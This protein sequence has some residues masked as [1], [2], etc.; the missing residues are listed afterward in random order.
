MRIATLLGVAATLGGVY[1]LL[2]APTSRRALQGA[3]AEKQADE[4]I[5]KL[6]ASLTQEPC[7]RSTIVELGEGLMRV[8]EPREALERSR[9]FFGRCGAYPRLLWV[10]Y[11]ANERLGK[12]PDA[13]DDATKLIESDPGS[14]DYWCW[15]GLIEEHHGVPEEAARD[16]R[17]AIAIEPAL[18]GIPI[19]LAD[20]YERLGR[21]CDAIEPLEQLVH[22]HPSSS[23]QLHARIERLSALPAC[24]A[25]SGTG[26]AL[27]R[28]PPGSTVVVTRAKVNDVPGKLAVDTGAT[29]VS[30]GP[31][32]AKQAKI[33]SRDW[34]EVTLQTAAGPRRA[35]I[36][37]VNSIG[38]AGVRAENIE[39]ALL[40]DELPQLDGLLGLSFLSRFALQLDVAK[41]ELRLRPR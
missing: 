2:R 22:Y 41:G 33:D 16:Y 28:F 3:V 7:D 25:L 31:R 18:S 8:G 21:P 24:K 38:V 9:T 14:K 12:W 29:Y 35:K 17:Q 23:M 37:R 36:G 32:L 6:R 19:N 4:R 11:S 1:R 10:T 30:L 26:E 27:I 5:D 15:R 34:A 13:I 20:L 40:D 39:V